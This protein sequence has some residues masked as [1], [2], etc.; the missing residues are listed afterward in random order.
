MNFIVGQVI[1]YRI[2]N[3]QAYTETFLVMLHAGLNLIH[4]NDYKSA[5]MI[6]SAFRISLYRNI[7][8]MTLK[9]NQ[10]ETKP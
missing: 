8:P 1:K 3:Y 10:I 6:L 5:E 4:A 2:T 9:I 7:V